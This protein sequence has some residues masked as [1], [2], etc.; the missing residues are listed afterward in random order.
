MNCQPA[1]ADRMVRKMIG[2]HG[3]PLRKIRPI[4]RDFYHIL[5]RDAGIRAHDFQA[6]LVVD[7]EDW[8]RDL[9]DLTIKK[10]TLPRLRV[11]R[12]PVFP[13]CWTWLR[14]DFETWEPDFLCYPMGLLIK[15][16]AA[17]WYILNPWKYIAED[18]EESSDPPELVPSF[19]PRLETT[20]T[21]DDFVGEQQD[22]Y[23][24]DDD[25][26][27]TEELLSR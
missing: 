20:Y 17:G 23:I 2:N 13:D 7:H 3:E 8:R 4:Q 25:F 9:F 6:W 5:K 18:G 16:P 21:V 15:Y 14:L 10:L 12:P 11:G 27:H 19:R 26:K 24:P 1:P 22:V